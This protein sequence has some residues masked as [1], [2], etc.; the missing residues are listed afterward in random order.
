MAPPARVRV[1]DLLKISCK[2]IVE[3]LHDIIYHAHELAIRGGRA[4]ALR[5]EVTYGLN[6]IM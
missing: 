4:G 5:N 1:R 2:E 3:G 6:S